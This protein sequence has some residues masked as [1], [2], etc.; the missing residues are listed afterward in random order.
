MIELVG[1][2]DTPTLRIITRFYAGGTLSGLIHQSGFRDPLP[3][4]LI[5]QI[6]RDMATGLSVIHAAEVVHNDVKPANVLMDEAGRAVISDLGVATVVGAARDDRLVKGLENPEIKGF[7]LP[8]AAPEILQKSYISGRPI[9]LAASVT[10]DDK[11]AD[12]YAYGITLWEI[13]HR[14]RPW[15]DPGHKDKRDKKDEGALREAARKKVTY[16][17]L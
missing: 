11:K 4:Q 13:L 5:A 17:A 7:T 16:I 14:Q 2:S 1:Y 3:R 8:Y 10:Q 15:Q 6:A 12:I 9:G